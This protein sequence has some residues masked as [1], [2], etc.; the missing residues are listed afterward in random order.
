MAPTLQQI[1]D[2]AK[3]G[4]AQ[5]LANHTCIHEEKFKHLEQAAE[6]TWVN[7]DDILTMQTEKKTVKWGLVVIYSGVAAL[8]SAIASILTILATVDIFKK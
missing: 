2:A 4:A 7:K 8:V 5:A 3:R 6:Q 1:E